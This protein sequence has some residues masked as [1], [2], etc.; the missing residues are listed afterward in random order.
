MTDQ[1]VA[2]D[3]T[4]DL[5]D[6]DETGFVWTFLHEARDPAL[7]EPGAIVAAG[8]P[9]APAVAEVVDVV[10]KPAGK[11]VHLR[12]LPGSLDDYIAM[13]RRTVQTGPRAAYRRPRSAAKTW[14]PKT[15]LNGL[16]PPRTTLEIPKSGCKMVAVAL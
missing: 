8:D 13:V 2:V 4:C 16:R 3:I 1:A 5:N 11:I 9:D 7:I 14:G 6:E 12:L 10:E 15:A